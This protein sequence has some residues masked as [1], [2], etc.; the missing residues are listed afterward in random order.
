MSPSKCWKLFI[1][2]IIIYLI[3][4]LAS[5]QDTY[6]MQVLRL[7][8]NVVARVLTML[9]I[10]NPVLVTFSQAREDPDANLT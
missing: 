4:D 7:G 3:Y 5:Y 8:Q 2:I 1:I 9:L 10:V 6:S